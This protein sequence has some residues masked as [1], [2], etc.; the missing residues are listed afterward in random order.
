VAVADAIK[1]TMA[2]LDALSR[3]M[4]YGLARHD[5]A[6]HRRDQ[7]DRQ[8]L[9]EA[10]ALVIIVVFIFLQNWRATSPL[11]T[12]PVSL[13][14]A[15]IFFRCSA[16]RSTCSR[17]SARSRHRHRRRRRDC[18]GRGGDAHIEHGMEPKAATIKRWRR[19]GPVV[20][21][22]LILIAVFVPV[23]FMGG[24][25]GRLYQ[26][27]AITIALSVLSRSSALTLSPALAGMLLKAPTGKKTR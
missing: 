16:S 7:R 9:F 15:F 19:L 14:G 21:I 23:G 10:V 6:G 1:A 13:V 27:F 22:G 20:A 25:T 17:C 26:Q 3:D 18:R 5:A 24:I 2:D 12:V 8:T 11:M 4:D